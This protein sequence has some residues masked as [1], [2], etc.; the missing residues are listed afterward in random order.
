[1]KTSSVQCYLLLTNKSRGKAYQVQRVLCQR[2][3]PVVTGVANII[4]A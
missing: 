1:M 2:E 4:D 3:L